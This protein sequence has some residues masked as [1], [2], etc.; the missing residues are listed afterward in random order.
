[1]VGQKV[2]FAI[3]HLYRKK[4]VNIRLY[5]F[6]Y[7]FELI[8]DDF[9][10]AQAIIVMNHARTAFLHD[11]GKVGGYNW[12][13]SLERAKSRPKLP[14][15]RLSITDSRLQIIAVQKLPEFSRVRRIP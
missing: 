13:T 11:G 9:N 5:L 15:I 14:R 4:L 2:L 10:V 12:E 3:Q 6:N 7:K 8:A 1:M